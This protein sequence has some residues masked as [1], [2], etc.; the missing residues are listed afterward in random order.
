MIWMYTLLYLFIIYC[1]FDL[2][3]KPSPSFAD[4]C[5]ASIIYMQIY[6]IMD[7]SIIFYALLPYKLTFTIFMFCWNK[8][9]N[10]IFSCQIFFFFS[11]IR[12]C[13]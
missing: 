11:E 4:N 3:H 6:V 1:D 8:L 7:W 10:G 12:L 2:V 5:Y 9:D 13:S